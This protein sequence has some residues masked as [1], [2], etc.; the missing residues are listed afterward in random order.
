MSF[1]IAATG[2]GLIG[3]AIEAV[4]SRAATPTAD[5][6]VRQEK[7]ERH[8]ASHAQRYV[9]LEA[10]VD[11]A[12]EV[13]HETEKLSADCSICLSQAATRLRARSV[14]RAETLFPIA[15]RMR[16][17][18]VIARQERRKVPTILLDEQ[19]RK[20]RLLSQVHPDGRG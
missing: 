6:I 14:V 8:N 16:P 19:G 5:E 7:L 15:N 18:I 2:C 20:V 4:L 3:L 12:H 9:S 11:C 13:R 10:C 1:L 17:A